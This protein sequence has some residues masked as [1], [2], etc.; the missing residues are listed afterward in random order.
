M[1]YGFKYNG[2]HSDDFDIEIVS[3]VGRNLGTPTED[4]EEEI[5]GY[6]GTVPVRQDDRG[7]II[8]VSFQIHADTPEQLRNRA[9]E[10]AEW[11]KTVKNDRNKPISKEIIFDDDLNRRWMGYLRGEISAEDIITHSQCEVEFFI[12]EPYTEAVDKKEINETTGE[13]EGSIP[14]HFEL[15]AVIQEETEDFELKLGDREFILD[16]ELNPGDVVKLDTRGRMVTVNGEDARSDVS[17]QKTSPYFQ[18]PPGEFS[19]DVV[20]ANTEIELEFRERW[21]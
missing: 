16:K 6:Q 2:T 19:F 15:K 18:I 21:R 12:P 8:P 10:V 11:L 17:I 1:S 9:H 7:K 14:V 20:P 5:P 4:T 13:N 3:V